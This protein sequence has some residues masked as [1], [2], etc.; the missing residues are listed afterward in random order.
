MCPPVPRSI[1]SRSRAR[2]R[3]RARAY[4]VSCSTSSLS[5]R[6]SSCDTDVPRLAARILAALRSSSGS[7]SVMFWLPTTIHLRR[8]NLHVNK[9]STGLRESWSREEPG[10]HLPGQQGGEQR[11]YSR[12]HQ[13]LFH[14]WRL[15]G[16]LGTWYMCQHKPVR[17]RAARRRLDR[18]DSAVGGVTA[19]RGRA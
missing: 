9:C 18:G 6:A 17:S 7:D 15:L 19:R 4:P 16:S 1:P 14:L 8:L 13:Q 3:S 2:L 5:I 12:F 10:N 11:P